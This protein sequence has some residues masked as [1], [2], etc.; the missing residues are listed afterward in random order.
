MS[1]DESLKG[2][3]RHDMS[4]SV[5]L[6]KERWSVSSQTICVDGAE[7]R[8]RQINYVM[9]VDVRR[10]LFC[11]IGN[12]LGRLEDRGIQIVPLK[13]TDLAIPIIVSCRR[14]L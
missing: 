6:H 14:T 5:W 4:L 10:L 3:P 7:R 2:H 11:C 12:V 1:N 9:Y 13:S 8:N